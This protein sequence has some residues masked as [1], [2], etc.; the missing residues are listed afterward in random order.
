MGP[1]R[2]NPSKR[3]RRRSALRVRSGLAAAAG[4]PVELDPRELEDVAA[5]RGLGAHRELEEPHAA[6][7]DDDTKW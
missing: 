6:S 1:P 7:Y 2:E 3:A 4:V 5:A